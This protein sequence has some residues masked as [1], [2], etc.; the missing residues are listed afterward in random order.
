M[1]S[2]WLRWVVAV[3]RL[4]SAG[5][6]V[7]WGRGSRRAP[8]SVV[9]AH[10]LS[11]PGACGIF[12][13]QGSNRRPF[14]WKVGSQSSNDQGSPPFS[15]PV[16]QDTDDYPGLVYTRLTGLQ[17]FANVYSTP[18]DKMNLLPLSMYSLGRDEATRAW[19]SGMIFVEHVLFTKTS[20]SLPESSKG[21]SICC[22][23]SS[24]NI[25]GSWGWGRDT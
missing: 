6:S 20:A 8:A 17:G 7:S 3:R 24:Q 19:S 2:F 5:A 13:D 9:V 18:A 14:R 12:P 11:C 21:L 16:E 25:A 22:L 1:L 4:P 15:S 10:R 23:F